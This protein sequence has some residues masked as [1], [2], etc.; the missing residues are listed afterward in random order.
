[1]PIENPT[2]NQPVCSTAAF[3]RI[4]Y[5]VNNFVYYSQVLVVPR[6]AGFCYQINDPT[7]D[8]NPDLIATDGGRIEIDEAV[9]IFRIFPYRGGILVFA[10]NG[11]WYVFGPD[12]G[13][14]ASNFNVSKISER[15]L[16]NVDGI[17]QAESYVYFLSTTG[18]HVLAATELNFIEV[19]DISE[20]TVRSWYLDNLQGKKATVEYRGKEKQIWF[21]STTDDNILVM[22]L[23]LNAFYP[24]QNS[25]SK[26]I[27]RGLGVGDE[28]FVFP[29][30]SHDGET[31]SYNFATDTSEDFKDFGVDQTA[32]L[33]SAYETL[34]KFAHK[35]AITYA[36]VYFNKTETTI[37]GFDSDNQVYLYDTPSSCLFQ[38]RWE[39]DNSNAYSKWVGRTTNDS[40]SGK[41]MELYNPM[42]RGF[43]PDAFPWTMDTGESI[44]HKKI[45][46]RGNG[47]AVQFRFEA[48]AEKDMQILGYNVNYSIKGRM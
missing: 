46:V 19:N 47:R 10:Q 29:N 38:A 6:G 26:Q 39:W 30:S 32:Y 24:Q 2:L 34:G 5:G 48:Q 45:K 35:K 14:T 7:S 43:V 17:V 21:V 9:N 37:T 25:G 42:R 40:G 41:K 13:F 27:Q 1:M 15:V 12:G 8:D 3:G 44:I 11:V 4:F 18:I 36:D 20:T 28:S 33:V 16:D 22:D 31:C 23:R